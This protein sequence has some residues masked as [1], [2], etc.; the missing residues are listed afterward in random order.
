MPQT[1]PHAAPCPLALP[2]ELPGSSTI[3][4]PPNL[5]TDSPFSI[6]APSL[7]HV[8]HNKSMLY[9][10]HCPPEWHLHP[11]PIKS[12]FIFLADEKALVHSKVR[13]GETVFILSKCLPVSKERQKSFGLRACICHTDLTWF[14]WD[15]A[16]IIY[17][18]MPLKHTQKMT[19]IWVAVISSVQRYL[20]VA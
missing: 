7:F 16:E 19:Q 11:G 4:G 2:S 1:Q 5:V 6:L 12:L 9:G 17:V 15:S 20:K 3:S 13:E 8:S 14:L 10:A 18:K